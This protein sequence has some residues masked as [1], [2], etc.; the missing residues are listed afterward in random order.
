MISCVFL[1]YSFFKKMWYLSCHIERTLQLL[2]TLWLWKGFNV[3]KISTL[4]SRVV[5]QSSFQVS[6]WK[7]VQAY[8]QVSSQA[9]VCP[10]VCCN[11]YALLSLTLTLEFH[12]KKWNLNKVGLT[13]SINQ[14]MAPSCNHQLHLRQLS[15]AY[16]S[17]F[18]RVSEA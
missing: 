13:F 16:I 6:V 17:S 12:E 11:C 8:V 3:K 7:S 10:S 15:N 9:S 5:S 4:G 1:T 14:M 2:V 18:L